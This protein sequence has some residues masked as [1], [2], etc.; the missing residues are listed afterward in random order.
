MRLKIVLEYIIDED[1]T[2]FMQ[3]RSISTNIR[4]TFEVIQYTKK[5]NIPAVIMAV[6]FEKCFDRI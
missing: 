6:D 2:G 3:N 1:Q 5:R 4:K